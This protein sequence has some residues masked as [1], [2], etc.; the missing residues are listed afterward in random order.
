VAAPPVA[1]VKSSTMHRNSF[2][3]FNF[4]STLHHEFPSSHYQFPQC[5]KVLIW[6]WTTRDS[7]FVSINYIIYSFGTEESKA[8]K[9]LP[10]NCHR[11]KVNQSHHPGL[12]RVGETAGN[13]KYYIKSH[14]ETKGKNGKNL[15]QIQENKG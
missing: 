4:W 7:F 2:A 6:V 11:Q 10:D 3:L 8:L 12:E 14:E 13:P 1:A 15:P 5:A 9:G